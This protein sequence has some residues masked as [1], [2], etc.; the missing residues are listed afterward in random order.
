MQLPQAESVNGAPNSTAIMGVDAERG[1]GD[2]QRTPQIVR[3]EPRS[4]HSTS[5]LNRF[6]SLERGRRRRPPATILPIANFCAALPP[7]V[8]S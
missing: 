3:P 8:Q 6:E 4:A 2:P 1:R 7:G 5:L